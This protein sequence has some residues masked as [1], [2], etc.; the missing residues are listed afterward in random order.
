MEVVGGA[1][2]AILLILGVE[3][4]AIAAFLASLPDLDFTQATPSAGCCWPG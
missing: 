4:I 2:S 3:I 1:A